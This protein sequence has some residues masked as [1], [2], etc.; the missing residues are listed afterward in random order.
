MSREGNRFPFDSR[1]ANRN[2]LK[3][4]PKGSGTYIEVTIPK[5]YKDEATGEQKKIEF[6]VW[7]HEHPVLHRSPLFEDITV[8]YNGE[9]MQIGNKFPVKDFTRFANIK[10]EWGT[11]RIYVSRETQN[12]EGHQNNLH[13][14]SNGIW[15]FS[16]PVNKKPGDIYGDRVQKVFYLDLN[17][18]VK[19]TSSG[20]PID[21]NRQ[22]FSQARVKDFAQILLH[23]SAIYKQDA[24][25][26]ALANWGD[27]SFS[28]EGPGGE[29]V[30]TPIQ[31]IA[32][33]AR[34][35]E[36]SYPL[37]SGG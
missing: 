28:Q 9:D 16:I 17:P 3:L 30:R 1:P 12:V 5:S 14:L 35:P 4:F 21:M 23:L 32:P 34:P 37:H 27:I 31:K 22:G 7:P 11:A 15:Q 20:Y 36:H 26:S 25:E 6:P 24:W 8:K 10:H 2:D 29:I 33:K 18:K 19:P 13:V